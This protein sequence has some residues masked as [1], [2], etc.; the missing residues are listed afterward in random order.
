MIKMIKKVARGLLFLFVLG[1]FC[2]S[3]Y[4]ILTITGLLKTEVFGVRQSDFCP[5]NICEWELNW[6]DCGWCGNDW[7]DWCWPC[8]SPTPSEPTPPEETPTPTPTP[9]EPTPPEETPTPTPKETP[10]VGGPGD[11]DDGF[12]PPGAPVCG[13]NSPDA[14]ILLSVTPVASVELKWTEVAEATHYSIAYGLESGNYTYG[15]E[16]TGKTTSFIVGGLDSGHDYCFAVRAVNDCAP[17][18]L[19]NEICTGGGAGRV[20]G[21]TTLAETGSLDWQAIGVLVYTLGCLCLGLGT[22]F[23]GKS[24]SSVTFGN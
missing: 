1:V 20:L 18:E 2:L 19:S 8:P 12:S 3:F 10:P 22:R 17:S 13:A 11:G 16:N 6:C 9:S 5:N 7:C 24:S 21:A 15:V 14:P 4:K 23:L